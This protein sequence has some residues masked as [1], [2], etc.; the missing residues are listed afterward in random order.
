MTQKRTLKLYYTVIKDSE[1]ATIETAD[2][3]YVCEIHRCSE[4]GKRSFRQRA[5]SLQ[6]A[7]ER[8]QNP[9]VLLGNNA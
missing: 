9:L 2:G 7:L 8:Y 4:E 5:R 3:Y 1:W 6:D